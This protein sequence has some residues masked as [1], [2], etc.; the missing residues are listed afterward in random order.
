MDHKDVTAFVNSPRFVPILIGIV[1][2]ILAVFI[3]EV[4]V[5]VGFHKAEFA[6]HWQE[7]YDRNFGPSMMYGM[8]GSGMPN[9]HGA[10]GK[11]ISITPP[12]FIIAGGN[13][14]EK[15]VRVSDDTIIRNGNQTVGTST[16]AAGEYVVIL[17]VPNDEG[18][19]EAGLIRVLPAPAGTGSTT[20][21]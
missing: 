1:C 16:L 10:T 20:T 17:G 19:I 5:V 4:G 13:E 18:E 11:I 3:F 6:E 15:I 7:N 9:P 21:P 8:P 2:I 12:T 14:P